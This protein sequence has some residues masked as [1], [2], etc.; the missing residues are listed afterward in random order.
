MDDRNLVLSILEN[1]ITHSHISCEKA[2]YYDK[3][4]DTSHNLGNRCPSNHCRILK[5]YHISAHSITIHVELN[6]MEIAPSLSFWNIM[7]AKIRSTLSMPKAF[8]ITHLLKQLLMFY[9]LILKA[10][11]LVTESKIMK[12]NH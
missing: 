10:D 9:M 7:N 4:W 2:L 3:S 5:T 1:D 11:P 6:L 12:L 8:I